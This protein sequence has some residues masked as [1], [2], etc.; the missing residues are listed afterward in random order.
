MDKEEIILFNEIG[1][2]SFVV[3]YKAFWAGIDV[4]VKVFKMR[5]VRRL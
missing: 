2:G 4:V 5:S 3:V 1:Y